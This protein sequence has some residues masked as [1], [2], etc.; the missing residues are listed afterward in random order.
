MFEKFNITWVVYKC[1]IK[2]IFLL[3]FKIP[4]VPSQHSTIIFF[5]KGSSADI[6][7]G[8]LQS[9]PFIVYHTVNF[10]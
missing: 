3:D 8:M 6:F 7:L 2:I 9:C 5:G 4:L 1:A 10:R